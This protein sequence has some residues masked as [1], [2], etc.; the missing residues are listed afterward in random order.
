M[1]QVGVDCEEVARFRKLPY[2]R[3]KNFYGKIFTPFEIRYCLSFRDPYPR[4]A[5]RFA[6]KEAAIKALNSLSKPTYKEIE[7]QKDHAGK[8]VIRVKRDGFRSIKTENLIIALSITHTRTLAVAFV[9]IA[10]RRLIK[11]DTV[12]DLLKKSSEHA[13]RELPERS[14]P[15]SRSKSRHRRLS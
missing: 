13:K 11:R 3:K 15:Q 8:P 12:R 6:A 10:D 7:I 5:A 2:E 9:V 1:I 14:F 4:F